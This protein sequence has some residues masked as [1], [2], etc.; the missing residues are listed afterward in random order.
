MVAIPLPTPP[1]CEGCAP[2]PVS[3]PEFLFSAPISGPPAG[4]AP[5]TALRV[6]ASAFRNSVLAGPSA[7]PAAANSQYPSLCRSGNFSGKR[8]LPARPSGLKHQRIVNLCGAGHRGRHTAR[9]L[10]LKPCWCY[11]NLR[12]GVRAPLFQPSQG[13]LA[14]L[15]RALP[16]H[17]RGPGFESLTAHHDQQL[18]AESTGRGSIPGP[19]ETASSGMSSVARCSAARPRAERTAAAMVWG[20]ASIVPRRVRD[21]VLLAPSS[22]LPH[23]NSAGWGTSRELAGARGT[24]VPR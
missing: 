2:G 10:A 1:S 19:M 15:V 5:G 13:R 4:F 11:S 6:M 23:S 21:A 24:F 18:R 17:G 16:S 7:A 12:S 20:Y 9:V 22:R 3:G 8:R 14:Q